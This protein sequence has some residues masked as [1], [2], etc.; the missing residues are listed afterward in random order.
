MSEPVLYD[1]EPGKSCI[2]ARVGK[3]T[4]K[5]G[6]LEIPISEALMM[7]EALI[8]CAY[9]AGDQQVI[10]RANAALDE[11]DAARDYH[12]SMDPRYW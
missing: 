4:I 11:D 9:L 2:K 5:D 10:D 12:E 7:G 1:I 3:L 8:G 6:V